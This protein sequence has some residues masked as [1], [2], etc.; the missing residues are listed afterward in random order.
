[1][2]FLGTRPGF[3]SKSQMVFLVFFGGGHAARVHDE[4]DKK[5]ED[6]KKKRKMKK[7]QK[8]RIKTKNK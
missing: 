3:F 5:G 2:G 6:E 8:K 1:M 7:K 4:K